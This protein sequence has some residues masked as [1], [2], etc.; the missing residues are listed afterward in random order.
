MSAVGYDVAGVFALDNWDDYVELSDT[1][2]ESST[3][4]TIGY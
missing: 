1:L 3:S 4:A 2:S